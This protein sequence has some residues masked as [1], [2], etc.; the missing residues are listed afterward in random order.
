MHNYC[1]GI[2]RR[3]RWQRQQGACYAEAKRRWKAM[4]LLSKPEFDSS[5]KIH[6]L[7]GCKKARLSVKPKDPREKLS[8]LRAVTS[9]AFSKQWLWSSLRRSTAEHQMHSLAFGKERN[10]FCQWL[11]INR[12]FISIYDDTTFWNHFE[13]SAPCEEYGIC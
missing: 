4:L 9:P 12:L 5:G 8:D 7:Q 2:V 11:Y 10:E 3:Q 6:K 1:L 13:S